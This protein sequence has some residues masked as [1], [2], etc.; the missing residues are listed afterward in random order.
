LQ[1]GRPK[2]EQIDQSGAQWVVTACENCKTQ[3]GDLKEHYEL[4]VEIK[5]IVDLVADALIV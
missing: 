4:S 5:G 2:A 1:G 3:L